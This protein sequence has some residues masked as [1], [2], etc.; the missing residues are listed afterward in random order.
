MYSWQTI[1]VL[2]VLKELQ[3]KYGVEV[4]G[5]GAAAQSLR[6]QLEGQPF[7]SLWRL[8]VFFPDRHHAQLVVTP[9]FYAGG[10]IVSLEPHLSELASR[11]S[12]P[13]EDQLPLVLPVVVGR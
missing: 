5:W 3:E 8:T 12:V 7:P 4:S 1:L 10:L 13:P 11:L 9:D 2:R 6:E